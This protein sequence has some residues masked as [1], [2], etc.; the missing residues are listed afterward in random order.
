MSTLLSSKPYLAQAKETL[1]SPSASV[2]MSAAA[3]DGM[4]KDK[5]FK[6][7][8][9]HARINAAA[10]AGVITQAM[11]DLAHDIRFYANNERHADEDAPTATDED[12]RRCFDFADAIAEML[13]VPPARLK[14]TQLEA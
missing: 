2:L 5:G 9:L 13:Y 12:A 4:L 1:T 11:A 14:K 7:G 3:I 6:D 10:Q 8:T